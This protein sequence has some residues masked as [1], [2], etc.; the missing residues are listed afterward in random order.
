[1]GG[2]LKGYDA[3]FDQG[4]PALFRDT[5]APLPAPHRSSHARHRRYAR[6]P[7]SIVHQ[8]LPERWIDLIN[9]LNLGEKLQ[10]ESAKRNYEPP[11]PHG[12]AEV[13]TAQRSVF[14]CA[15]VAPDDSE[16]VGP[17]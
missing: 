4:L 10:A 3:P 7:R 8:P 12:L 14:A 1:M 13:K 17:H 16:V 6:L 2:R 11:E 9:R 5:Q 15:A